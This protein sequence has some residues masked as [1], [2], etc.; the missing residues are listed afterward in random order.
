MHWTVSDFGEG[1]APDAVRLHAAN[2]ELLL[3]TCPLG[4]GGADLRG[5]PGFAQLL[6]L[7]GGLL[8]CGL[9]TPLFS[10]D[11]MLQVGAEFTH[12]LAQPGHE[13]D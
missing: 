7:S 12:G 10:Q 13:K 4:L 8:R 11:A 5:G 3:Q 1:G 2:E 9:K 6:A